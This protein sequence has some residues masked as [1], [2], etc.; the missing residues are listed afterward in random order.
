MP[1]ENIRMRWVRKMGMRWVREKPHP[2]PTTNM[3]KKTPLILIEQNWK[4]LFEPHLA[5][6]GIFLY[7]IFRG[8][9][10]LV[11]TFF[12]KRFFITAP[13]HHFTIQN[14]CFNLSFPVPVRS[15]Q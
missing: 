5:R 9:S 6:N 15:S 1:E 4:A 12:Q 13:H 3:K 10:Y 11:S 8:E 14:N 7:H 2:I